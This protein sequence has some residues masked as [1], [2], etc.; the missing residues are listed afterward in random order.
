MR[1]CQR[2]TSAR[3]VCVC[4][5]QCGSAGHKHTNKKNGNPSSAR[6]I[7]IGAFLCAGTRA[8]SQN[9]AEQSLL[10]STRGRQPPWYEADIVPSVCHE[11][12]DPSEISSHYLITLT[13]YKSDTQ[14]L[15]QC[16]RNF[17]AGLTMLSSFFIF[18]FFLSFFFDQQ[19]SLW[20]LW[21]YRQ[22]PTAVLGLALMS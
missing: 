10:L 1:L 14:Y 8:S 3:C 15:R 22:T 5:H 7:N 18:I 12:H 4:V 16:E 6:I 17:Q 2:S 21:F 19:R 9:G 11:R 20:H 13:T